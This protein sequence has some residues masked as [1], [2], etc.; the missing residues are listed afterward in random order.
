[1][2]LSRLATLIVVASFATGTLHAQTKPADTP[3]A[4][5]KAI[6]EDCAKEHGKHHDHVKEKGMGSGMVSKCV[7]EKKGAKKSAKKPLHDHN[8][9][10]KAN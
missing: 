10:H 3:S 4:D 1:M 9:E 2:K 8:K 5:E 6:R 7:D